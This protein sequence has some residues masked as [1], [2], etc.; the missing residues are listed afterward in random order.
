MS[1]DAIAPPPA[2]QPAATPPA[3]AAAEA[4]SAP[5]EDRSVPTAV[6]I[7]SYA[8]SG[9]FILA[10]ICAIYVAKP[11]LMPVVAAVVLYILL[12]PAVRLLARLHVPTALGAAI[13][14][15]GL[16]GI[17]AT[18]IYV[19]ADPAAAWLAQAPKVVSQI[20]AKIRAPVEELAKARSRSKDWSRRG[21]EAERRP[22][23]PPTA[24]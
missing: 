14:I 10:S 22:R 23:P 11:I 9:L 24:A 4:A 17:A 18:G 3:G 15:T 5:A 16:L 2:A 12:W 6:R 21:A 7:Q 13:V 20:Q 19:W 1:I 8:I